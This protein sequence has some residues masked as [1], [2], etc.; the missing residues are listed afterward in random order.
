ME[1]V[2]R[3]MAEDIAVIKE[4]LTAVEDHE[5]RIRFLEKALWIAV[6]IM[7][8]LNIVLKWR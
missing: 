5:K 3:Q 6:G 2:I 7:G 1:D 8:L 4:K